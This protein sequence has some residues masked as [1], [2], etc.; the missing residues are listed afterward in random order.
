MFTP[1][2]IIQHL[3]YARNTSVDHL[4][5][6]THAL[7]GAE[8]RAIEHAGLRKGG[9]VVVPPT[10]T[11]TALRFY[12]TAQDFT[13]SP[14]HPNIEAITVAGV[15]SSAL[16]AA[17]FARDVADAYGIDVAA[18]V[19]SH[20]LDDVLAETLGGRWLW[21]HAPHSLLATE[22]RTIRQLANHPPPR[23]KA[24]V[25][26]SKGSLLIN[27]ALQH[28][29]HRPTPLT[30]PPAVVTFGAVVN[31]PA[32]HPR[33]FQFIGELD[34]LGQLNSTPAEPRITLKQAAHWLNAK[35]PLGIDVTA[36]LRQ[37]VRL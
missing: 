36:I 12:A 8:Q 30:T 7:S 23:L 27:A 32:S 4:F 2:G 18:V 3:A 15:G 14:D 35:V 5:Y 10:G 9:V 11:A 19:S 34:V 26:H 16:G 6:N 29:A 28:M 1:L 25:G 13:G 37:H 22:Q 31:L 17:A 20:G 33:K 21:G 24:L